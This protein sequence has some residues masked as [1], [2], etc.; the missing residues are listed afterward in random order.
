MPILAA[1]LVIP[2]SKAVPALAG[3]TGLLGM[4]ALSNKVNE[5]I[6]DNPEES[7]KILS[8]IIPGVGIGEIFMNKE[9]ISLED[10]DE[11]T[12]EEAQD[13]SKEEKAELM[14]QGGKSRSKDKRQTMID[15]SEKLG[16]SSEGKEKQDIEY[17]IDERYDEGGVEDAPKP[18]FD[19][20]KFFRNRRADGGA[21]GI[22]VL[23]EEKKPRKDFNTGGT[24]YDSRASA[25]DYATALDKVGAGTAAQKRQSLSDYLGNVISTQ[26]QKLGNAAVI[27]LQAAKGVLGIQGTPITDSMQ[28]SLQQ[29]IQDKISKTGKLK[30]GIDYRDYGVQTTTGKEFEGFGKRS[31]TDPEAALATT[32]GQADYVVDPKTGKITFTG[33][34]AYD[35]RDDQFGG[36]GKFISKGGVFSDQA[37]QYNPDITLGSDFMKQFNQ[38]KYPDYKTAALQS[39]YYKNNPSSLDFDLFKSA[40]AR[41]VPDSGIKTTIGSEGNIIT[42]YGNYDPSN[43]YSAYMSNRGTSSSNPF[44][45]Q[46]KGSQ[47]AD[48]PAIM[49][50]MYGDPGNLNPYYADGGRVG[51]FMGGDPLTGQA[52]AIYN[53]MNSYG[54]SDQEIANALEGQGLYT[55]GSTPVVEEPVTNTVQNIINQGGGDGPPNDPPKDPFGGLGYSSANFGLGANKDVMDY[56]ADAY[57][58]GRTLT[59]QLNKIGLGIFSALKNIPTP[60]NLARKAFE[61]YKEQKAIEEAQKEAARLDAERATLDAAYGRGN[62]GADFTGGRF[63]GA[64]SFS[65]YSADPTGYSG[66]SKDGGIMGYG[67]KSGTP[68]GLAAMFVEKR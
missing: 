64:D 14:K 11:M 56:E 6:Q 28:A 31:F 8:T 68:K 9:K 39:Q 17:E 52:L 65:D 50:A 21:I 33:G 42:N 15:L 12:D 13:L 23:F 43:T 2:F 55:P 35:F 24:T 22:E 18:K 20:K 37:T 60:F 10:L 40:Y 66:S 61:N 26:G 41:A 4:T 53:S 5:Y 63:D 44:F 19:Y 29:I 62:K 45:D 67:G 58:V 16:L 7:M 59:G 36:L 47:Y 48:M 32:L 30:G 46:F 27:P 54:F 3:L 51:L 1:P 34:T 49:K 25:V 57:N 38:P